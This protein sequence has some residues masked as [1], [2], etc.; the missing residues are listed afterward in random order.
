MWSAEKQEQK[1]QYW[2]SIFDTIPVP[3]FIV[4]ADVRIENFNTA[5]EP[6]LGPEPALAL[7]QPG[8]EALHC[9]NAERSGCGQSGPCEDCVIRNSVR[10]AISGRATRR[11]LHTARLREEGEVHAIDL[12]VTTSVLPYTEPPR[13]LLLLENL[14]EIIGLCGRGS[15]RR[16][17]S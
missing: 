9:I 14:T 3:T 13:A 6:F 11:E 12:L 7:Y 2:R 4:D 5:A 17:A 10:R 8:G 16:R 15:R 1:V